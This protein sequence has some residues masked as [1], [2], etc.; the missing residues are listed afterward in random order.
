MWRV[1]GGKSPNCR[2]RK[3]LQ[4]V[5]L[6]AIMFTIIWGLSPGNFGLLATARRVVR[7][8]KNHGPMGVG[9]VDISRLE[10]QHEQYHRLVAIDDELRARE[11]Q[12]WD[13]VELLARQAAVDGVESPML[14]GL[15][16]SVDPGTVQ[17][18]EVAAIWERQSE[19]YRGTLRQE[20]AAD[21]AKQKDELEQALSEEIARLA[22]KTQKKILKRQVKLAMLTLEQKEAD[23]LLAE[24]NDLQAEFEKQALQVE[25]KYD[26]KLNALAAEAEAAAYTKLLAFNRQLMEKAIDESDLLKLT[27]APFLPGE[28]D[29]RGAGTRDRD[30]GLQ[31]GEIVQKEGPVNAPERMWLELALDDL[32]LDRGAMNSLEAELFRAKVIWER[33]RQELVEQRNA[34]LRVIKGDIEVSI[35]EVA[36][37]RG[38][39]VVVDASQTYIPGIDL[40]DQ[41]LDMLRGE[42]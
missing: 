4:Q 32:V 10:R 6:L 15:I 9:L 42:A 21:F 29:G 34:I 16:Q 7:D 30:R 3:I 41:V 12:W 8:T 27:P 22:G 25:E 38:L 40:T 19:E 18:E 36:R 20:T 17:S 39:A 26:Q 24:I 2:P 31:A 13:Y 23:V 11:G 35:D 37:Q 5:A 28:V 33:D 14:Q 1:L